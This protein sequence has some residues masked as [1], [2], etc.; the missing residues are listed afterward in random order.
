MSTCSSTT[1]NCIRYFERCFGNRGMTLSFEN[2]LFI[3]SEDLLVS[4]LYG[5][6]NY[7]EKKKESLRTKY[8]K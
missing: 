4:I 1:G 2:H 6:Y 8:R 7:D 3:Y 5:G